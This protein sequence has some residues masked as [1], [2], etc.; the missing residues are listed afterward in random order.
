MGY[1]YQVGKTDCYLSYN[2]SWAFYKYIDKDRGF[3]FLYHQPLEFVVGALQGM[4]QL[5][6][7]RYG[8]ACFEN[9][10]TQENYSDKL[11]VLRPELDMVKSMKGQLVRYDGWA[12]TVGNSYY[13]A[14]KLLLLCQKKIIQGQ[15]EE[16]INGD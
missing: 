9:Y 4:L 14:G 10:T 11:T 12:T 1:D 16:I 2:H 13:F 8:K 7:G 15:A 5:M 6:R 3:R